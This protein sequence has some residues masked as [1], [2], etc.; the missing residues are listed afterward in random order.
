MDLLSMDTYPH[1]LGIDH[2]RVFIKDCDGKVHSENFSNYVH[3]GSSSFIDFCRQLFAETSTLAPLRG[4]IP[5]GPQR[6]VLLSHAN[7]RQR[8]HANDDSLKRI[9]EIA[10]G[11]IRNLLLDGVLLLPS[12]MET[13]MKNCNALRRLSITR[14]IDLYPL[15]EAV[16]ARLEHLAVRDVDEVSFYGAVYHN[17]KRL[18]SLEVAN[19]ARSVASWRCRGRSALAPSSLPELIVSYGGQL[20][21][22]RAAD[23]RLYHYESIA[24]KCPNVDFVA[25]VQ[26][27]SDSVKDAMQGLGCRLTHL[28]V[29]DH[30]HKEL[31]LPPSV[32]AGCTR[33]RTLEYA[34]FKDEVKSLETL[35]SQTGDSLQ[36]LVLR[37]VKSERFAH[38]LAMPFCSFRELKVEARFN[39]L[40]FRDVAVQNKMLEKVEIRCNPPRDP[41]VFG[42]FF[43]DVVTAFAGCP[44]LSWLEV[45]HSNEVFPKRSDVQKVCDE[46]L[47]ETP[48]L[49][50]W[51]CGVKY[52]P[53][54]GEDSLGEKNVEDAAK[55]DENNG[56]QGELEGE[57]VAMEV[58][59]DE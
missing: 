11:F 15:L 25:E 52:F 28:V 17:C 56:V 20:R 53:K 54:K 12:E 16:G 47:R 57:A 41:A 36:K 3:R 35:L 40:M 1:I 9:I 39:A 45:A 44:K 31:T 6:L 5:D 7:K 30:P 18:T 34:S 13:I 23:L 14:L 49:E 8:L 29:K 46:R 26:L 19:T 27:I 42:A 32:V 21:H 43:V 59:V 2:A 55:T 58:D 48:E 22:C 38:V 24:R 33:L 37:R 4:T 50:V 51:M 10:G